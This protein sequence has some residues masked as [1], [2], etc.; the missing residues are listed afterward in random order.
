MSSRILG[1]DP[2]DSE[3][4]WIG[5]NPRFCD[6]RWARGTVPTPR[7]LI[8]VSWKVETGRKS[9]ELKTPADAAFVFWPRTNKRED[10]ITIINGTPAKSDPEL[11]GIFR[12]PPGT[13]RLELRKGKGNRE[14]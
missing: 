1:I 9:I 12:V 5:I 6:L 13:Y 10:E 2:S 7:G 14:K 3:F 4:H 11:G 8:S